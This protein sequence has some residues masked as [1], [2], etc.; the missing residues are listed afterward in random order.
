M[1]PDPSAAVPLSSLPPPAEREI[2]P[3]SPGAGPRERARLRFRKDGPLRWLSHHDLLRTFERL[4]RRSGLP[5][6]STQGF[7]PHPRIVFALSL[8]LGVIGRAEIVDIEFDEEIDPV[9]VRD[10]LQSHCPPGLAFL[11]AY[12]I[13]CN[14]GV[15]VAGLCYGIAVPPERIA[16]V[17]ERIR[18]VLQAGPCWVE[19]SKPTRRR[20]DIR[21][22]LR[23]VRLDEAGFLEIDLWLLSTGTARPDE[24]L[25]LLGLEDLLETGAVLERLRLDMEEDMPTTRTGPS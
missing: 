8:P 15:H 23:D 22:F 21:P 18:Q 3:A 4:L 5:F 1:A 14:A 6:R 9:A 2:Q 25:A 7:H 16:A 17:G 12:R 19:R 13:A 11:D 24:V 20:L 10:R